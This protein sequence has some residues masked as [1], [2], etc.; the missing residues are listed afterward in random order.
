MEFDIKRGHYRNL[1]NDGLKN[2]MAEV[3]GEVSTEGDMLV[4]AFGSIKKLKV[5]L[6][7]K[8]T[9][10]VETETDP[11]TT[12]AVALETIRK[13]NIFMEKATGFTS[14]QRRERLTKK[15]KEGKF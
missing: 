1:E 9:L 10:W 8:S 7:D 14:K 4:A 6:M 2:I 12:D 11:A 13:Y 15:A 3:F 5:K